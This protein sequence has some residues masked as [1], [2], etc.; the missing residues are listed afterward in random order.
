MRGI[1]MVKKVQQIQVVLCDVIHRV[2]LMQYTGIGVTIEVTAIIE[3][4]SGK[5]RLA[6]HLLLSAWVQKGE[7]TATDQ[8]RLKILNTFVIHIKAVRL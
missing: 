3:T 6:G 1:A 2:S 8:F 7:R 5:P 4:V